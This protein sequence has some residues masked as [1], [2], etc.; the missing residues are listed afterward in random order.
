ME[1]MRTLEG[2]AL[3]DLRRNLRSTIL[4]AFADLHE[5]YPDVITED[6]HVTDAVTE[7]VAALVGDPDVIESLGLSEVVGVVW[8]KF[9][10]ILSRGDCYVCGEDG[11]GVYAI[12]ASDYDD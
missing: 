2:A 5:T 4:D 10:E 7:Q 3:K 12:E 6:G 1:G 11:V 9:D 8:S